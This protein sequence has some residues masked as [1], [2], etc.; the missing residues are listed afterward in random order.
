MDLPFQSKY[1]G[2]T[3]SCL[4]IWNASW[5][6]TCKTSYMISKSFYDAPE[7]NFIQGLQLAI[8]ASVLLW[9]LIFALIF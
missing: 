7:S 2:M 4:Y 1:E 8:P 6:L 3:I 9:T 5:H